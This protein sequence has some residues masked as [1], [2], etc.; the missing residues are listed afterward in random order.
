MT[1]SLLLEI[2]GSMP[3][4]RDA[5]V[6]VLAGVVILALYLFATVFDA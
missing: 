3:L 1:G 5:A 2:A 4:W 6:A